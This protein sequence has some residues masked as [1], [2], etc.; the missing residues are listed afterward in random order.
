MASGDSGWAH[1]DVMDAPRRN[2][3][4]I[5]GRLQHPVYDV[6]VNDAISAIVKAIDGD[7]VITSETTHYTAPSSGVTIAIVHRLT[8][9]NNDTGTNQVS[10][11]IVE[12]G[13][14]RTAA[15]RIFSDV[16]LAGE[17]VQIEGPFFLDPSDTVRSI[18]AAASANEVALRLEVTELKTQIDGVNLIVDD[19]NTLTTSLASYY[20]CPGSG[21]TH[22]LVVAVTVC[23][24]DSTG[25]TVT[26]EIR[27]SGGST[28]AKQYVLN[29]LIFAGETRIIGGF[30]LEPG[31]AIY[32]TASANSVV[33]IRISP[34]EFEVP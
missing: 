7:D 5:L 1:G 26:I 27:P 22:A 32:A 10:L 2:R 13:G 14:S 12:S 8:I 29:R 21:V 18:S 25:R 19:G 23:N 17:E 28:S 34:V 4:W 24:T 16:L 11:H 30:V 3:E 33:G 31:D 15:N 9:V 20:A 6:D